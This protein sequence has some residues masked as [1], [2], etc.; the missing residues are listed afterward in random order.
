VDTEDTAMP[1]IGSMLVESLYLLALAGLCVYGLN[2]Y[3]MLALHWWHGCRRPATKT[4]EPPAVWPMVTVQLPV[5]NERYVARRVLG[6]VGAFD[7]PH[8]R[9]EIQLLDD[10]TDATTEILGEAARELR[11]RGVTVTHRRREVRSGFKAGALAAGLAD[12]RGEFVA[13]F[14]A[15]FVPPPDFLRRTIPHFAD[16]QVA[17]VQTRWGHLNRDFSWLTIAQS[18]ALDAHFGVEQSAR[19]WGRLFLN[20]NGTAGV[21]R[22]AAIEDAGGWAADTVTEDLDLSYRA[23]LRGWRVRYVPHL[24]CPAELPVLVTGFKSQQRRWAQGSIQ[25]AV[26]LLPAVLRAPQ[27]RWVKYQAMIH[28][29]AYL[30]H[31]CMLTVALLSVPAFELR[32]HALPAPLIEGVGLACSLVMFGPLTLLMYAQYVLSPQWWRRIWQLPSLMLMGVGVALSTSLGILGAVRGKDR[33]FIRTPKFGIGP[34]GGTWE[35]KAYVDR[36]LWGGVLDLV[37]GAY[38]MSTIWQAWQ[39]AQYGM[40]PFLALSTAGFLVVGA[41]TILH[42]TTHVSRPRGR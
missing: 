29:T 17:V 11:D 2:T 9:L 33:E 8:D 22:I 14:D 7:Y 32:G 31:P 38:T 27:P 20:F 34:A 35:G 4:P 5:Y 6:A 21:W 24:T 3:I 19:A 25:T 39:H 16:A 30:A 26:K 1:F 13:I 37:L 28:L 15:D 12:A 36:R 40:L 42:S 23:Q 41:L 10:S 18:F